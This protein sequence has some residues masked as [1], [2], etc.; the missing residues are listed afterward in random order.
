MDLSIHKIHF[1]MLGF[2]TGEY[3][4]CNHFD[5]QK[6]RSKR[7]IEINIKMNE[8]E[9]TNAFAEHLFSF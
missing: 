3:A 7:N 4:L 9:T 5:G 8:H 1:E 6:E 2:V